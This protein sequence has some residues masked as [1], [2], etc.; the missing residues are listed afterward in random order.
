MEENPDH[1]KIQCIGRPAIA[2]TLWG[3]I[4]LSMYHFG[5]SI[6]ARFCSRY[7][8]IPYT[9]SAGIFL[10]QIFPDGLL[11]ENDIRDY[12]QK[13]LIHLAREHVGA[14]VAAA[15]VFLANLARL[16]F[17]E[18]FHPAPVVHQGS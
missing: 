10:F 13:F 16:A 5:W 12:H 2:C 11:R 15:F 8:D 14:T 7:L 4:H 3:S 6:C 1:E 17:V 9:Y 18:I